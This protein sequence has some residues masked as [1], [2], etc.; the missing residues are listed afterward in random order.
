MTV[1]NGAVEYERN[2]RPA[3]F[4]SKK[5]KV[6]LSFV[7]ED[8][9]D[10]AAVVAKVMDMAVSEVHRRLGLASTQGLAEV[11]EQKVEADKGKRIQRAK[12]PPAEVPVAGPTS[13]AASPPAEVAVSPVVDATSDDPAAI[14]EPEPV[15]EVEEPGFVYTDAD[16]QKAIHLAIEKGTSQAEIKQL[17]WHQDFT[18]MPGKRVSEIAIEKRADFIARLKAMYED[19]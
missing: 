13:E 5:A 10:P 6:T 3:D 9:S 15:V 4:E 17:I 16:L 12:A 14:G 7:V 8:G 19:A 11:F 18:G 1:T 2:V